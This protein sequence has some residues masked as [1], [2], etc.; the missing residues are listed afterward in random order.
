LDPDI[1][2]LMVEG[3][4]LKVQQD[5]ADTSNNYYSWA[6]KN[7][8]NN[9]VNSKINE[10]GSFTSHSIFQWCHVHCCGHILFSQI[11]QYFLI[12]FVCHCKSR[13]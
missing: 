3:K 4:H 2:E 12:N 6:I 10:D 9:N 1:Q 8:N 5:I 11:K 13:E 7:I